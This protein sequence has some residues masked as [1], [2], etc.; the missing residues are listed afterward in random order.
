MIRAALLALLVLAA[1]CASDPPPPDRYYRLESIPAESAGK[2]NRRIV[3]QPFEA[4]GVYSERAL[5]FRREA[6]GGTAIE[7]YNYHYWAEPPALMLGDL[8]ADHLRGAFGERQVHRSA[9]RVRPDVVVRPR[10]RNLVQVLDPEPRALLSIQFTVTDDVN[11]P[12]LVLDYDEAAPLPGTAP[13]EY[14]EAINRMAGE[15]A[16]QLAAK[17]AALPE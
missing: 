10:L 8:V 3:V 4:H 2:W 16:A 5:L 6:A 11:S 12:L 1:G 9:S 13:R 17:L 14:I 7:Q 15:A